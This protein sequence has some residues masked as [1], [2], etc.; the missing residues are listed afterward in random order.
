MSRDTSRS[1]VASRNVIARQWIVSGLRRLDDGGGS[2]LGLSVRGLLLAT[3]RWRLDNMGPRMLGPRFTCQA[4]VGRDSIPPTTSL[5][6]RNIFR[7]RCHA[8]KRKRRHLRAVG[9]ARET[10]FSSC[11][12]RSR[13]SRFD[14]QARLGRNA[15]RLANGFAHCNDEN[16]IAARTERFCGQPC[17]SIAFSD[18][19]YSRRAS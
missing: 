9:A 12:S 10:L 15:A 7:W 5:P 11:R 18:C 13:W 14:S 17:F 6:A 1:A 19:F 4:Q 3:S 2:S 8:C 16:A